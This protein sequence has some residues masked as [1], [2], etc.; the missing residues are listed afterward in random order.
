MSVVPL[1]S[2]HAFVFVVLAL[3]VVFPA[4]KEKEEHW[5]RGMEGNRK[6]WGG[7]ADGRGVCATY[8][9]QGQRQRPQNFSICVSSRSAVRVSALI[10]SSPRS[11][12]R[13]CSANDGERERVRSLLCVPSCLAT[14]RE[15]A[16]LHPRVHG[17][18]TPIWTLTALLVK[19]LQRP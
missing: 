1:C 4:V 10:S 2:T 7:H 17:R 6:G 14:P 13:N 11:T 18:R 16:P 15:R 12:R 5:L 19:R 9:R 8:G 3:K